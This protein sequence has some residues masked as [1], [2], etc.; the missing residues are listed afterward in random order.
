MAEHQSFLSSWRE[1]LTA[2]RNLPPVLRIVWQAGPAVVGFGLFFRLFASL[3]PLG[4]LWAS[5]DAGL[6]SGSLALTG[7]LF[8]EHLYVQAPQQV[9]NA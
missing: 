5:P 6:V 2:L 4:L 9:P 7:L 1:R 3:L 8:W